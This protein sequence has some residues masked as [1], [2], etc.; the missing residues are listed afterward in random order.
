[1]S[2]KQDFQYHDLANLFP[3]FEP[4]SKEFAEL[5]DDIQKHGQ[6][7]P[8]VLFQG[9][10]IDGRNRYEACRAAGILTRFVRGEAEHGLGVSISPLAWVLSKNLHR[11]H[12][13]ESQRALVAARI[14]TLPQGARTDLAPIGAKSQ[15]AAA[16]ML[17]V[18]RRS[19]QRAHSV[20]ETG[21]RELIA[22]VERGKISVSAAAG[23]IK[24]QNDR[25][26][27]NSADKYIAEQESR[28]GKVDPKPQISPELATLLK[29]K[30]ATLRAWMLQHRDDGVPNVLAAF[31]AA[32]AV[33]EGHLGVTP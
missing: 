1:M 2:D 6:V 16:G 15:D 25:P 22:S 5:A 24:G 3:M 33:I 27:I 30:L 23:T 13:N 20:I 31:A 11:R 4:D 21:D 17:N 32:V 8:C 19:V 29:G 10:I 18:S 7:E 12:L 26:R 14:A 9:K 28:L